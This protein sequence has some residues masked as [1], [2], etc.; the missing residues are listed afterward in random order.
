[1]PAIANKTNERMDE[2]T[3]ARTQIHQYGI[4]SVRTYVLTVL[5]SIVY[6]RSVLVSETV[7][8][9][10]PMHYSHSLHTV[11]HRIAYHPL[12]FRVF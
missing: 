5:Y 6:Y 3:H 2:A 8:Q 7:S 1:M 4:V 12:G 9:S 11:T 10:S